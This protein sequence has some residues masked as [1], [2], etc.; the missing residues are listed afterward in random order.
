MEHVSHLNYEIYEGLSFDHGG[1]FIQDV[2]SFRS[3]AHIRSRL[4]A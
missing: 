2:E 1:V 3:I 4:V